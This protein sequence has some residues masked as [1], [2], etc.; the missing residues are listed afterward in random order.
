MHYFGEA[1]LVGAV[2]VLVTYVAIAI[3]SRIVPRPP[4]GEHY[5]KYRVMEISIFVAG[6]LT[7]LLFEK[8]GLNKAYC[9]SGYACTK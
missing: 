1:V 9:T 4:P 8:V 5:N 6:F 7:H 2:L 3:T